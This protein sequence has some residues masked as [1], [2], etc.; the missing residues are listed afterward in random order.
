MS[1]QGKKRGRPPFKWHGPPGEEFVRAVQLDFWQQQRK[2]ISK[3]IYEVVWIEHRFPDLE[4]HSHR[5]LERQYL[6]VK[7]FWSLCRVSI[8]EIANP[9]GGAEPKFALAWYAHL[10]E[11]VRARSRHPA[12]DN[13]NPNAAWVGIATN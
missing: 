4:K 2:S 6:N 11:P 9:S 3:A 8:K 5:Y 10:A 12:L 1:A 7:K 13:F